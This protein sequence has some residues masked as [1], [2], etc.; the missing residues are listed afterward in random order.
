MRQAGVADPTVVGTDPQG[1]GWLYKLRVAEAS[2]FEGF[3]DEAA[4]KAFVG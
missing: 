4:Y 1:A 2:A 3:M